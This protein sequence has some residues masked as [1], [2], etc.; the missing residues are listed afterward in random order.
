[1]NCLLLVSLK[2]GCTLYMLL[3][4][5]FPFDPHDMTQVTEGTYY[6]MEGVG[7]NKISPE[8]KSLVR[9]LL[10]KSPASRIT[11]R[12]A[13][14]HPWLVN[15]ARTED[16]GVDYFARLKHLVLCQKLKGFFNDSNIKEVKYDP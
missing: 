1:M 4:G 7:W 8:A 2:A 6:R 13:L 11:I 9:K 16:L 3:S 10:V 5:Y 15:E 14:Q 12:E